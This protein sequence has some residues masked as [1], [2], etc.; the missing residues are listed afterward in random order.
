MNV[1]GCARRRP[2]GFDRREVAA[3]ESPRLGTDSSRHL[4]PHSAVAVAGS[5]EGVSDLVKDR[6]PHLILRAQRREMLRQSDL[7]MGV[8]RLAS[9]PSSIVPAEL[10]VEAVSLQE[11]ECEAAC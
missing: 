11:V 10:P 9:P 6:L 4:R 8:V 2:R 1:P 7:P 3:S 5:N